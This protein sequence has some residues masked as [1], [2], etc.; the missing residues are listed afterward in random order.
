[1][2]K[3]PI[4][5]QT[6]EHIIEGDMI[7]VDKTEFIHDLTRKGKYYF[8]ARP[9]RFGKSLLLTTLKSFFEGKK[10]LFKG[11][12]IDEKEKDW[13]VYPVVHLDYSLVDYS[14]SLEI[15]KI[16]LLEN[17]QTIARQY[18]LQ[19]KNIVIANAFKELIL[20][21]SEKYNRQVVVLID[22][23]DKPLVDSLT[24]EQKFEENRHVLQNLYGTIK[25]LDGHLRFVMLTGVSRFSKV[26]VFSRLNNLDDISMNKAYSTMVGFTQTELET[27]FKD[28]LNELATTFSLPLPDILFGVKEWYNGFSFDGIHKLYNPFSILKL[29]TEYEFRN[30]WFSTG[31]PTFL[32][33]LIKE[34][35]QLPEEFEH[36][37]VNDL[38][39]STQQIKNF[40][41]I[42]L[43][44]QTGYLTIE[45][46]GRDGLR[47]HYFLNYPNEEVRHSF[48][49]YIA[50][51]KNSCTVE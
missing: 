1:M 45:K 47:P 10:A 22:E 5:I 37:K 34:Q 15:F 29:F 14:T 42:P 36:L 19:L 30:Y 27:Y 20:A 43:L 11:L 13:T 44:Y 24:N 41:L 50:A 31:T 21:L 51:A 49:T 12:Y 23:Y 35:K 8:F 4:S 28:H 40:P 7:Y 25:G 2:K 3:L 16:S 38:T 39:G 9:R 17:L 18:D 6:F 33:D 48:L 32:I 46:V 26:S